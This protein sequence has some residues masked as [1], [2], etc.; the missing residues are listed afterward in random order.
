MSEID[1]AAQ[2]IRVAFEGSEIA[3][4]IA[5]ESVTDSVKL[6]R[7]IVSMFSWMHEKKVYGKEVGGTNIKN[8]ITR[9]SN[10]LACEIPKVSIKDFDIMA[11]KMGILY[12]KIPDF[13]SNDMYYRM[14]FKASDYPKVQ[15]VMNEINKKCKYDF[16]EE[17]LDKLIKKNEKKIE[18]LEKQGKKKSGN[19]NKIMCLKEEIF[20]YKKIKENGLA[21]SAVQLTDYINGIPDNKFNN[22]IGANNKSKSLKKTENEQTLTINM[23]KKNVVEENDKAVKL[24]IPD[25]KDGHVWISKKDVMH[26]DNEN[27][28]LSLKKEKSYMTYSGNNKAMGAMVAEELAWYLGRSSTPV[29]YKTVADLEKEYAYENKLSSMYKDSNKAAIKINEDAFLFNGTRKQD[30]YLI[31]IDEKTSVHVE[32]SSIFKENGGYVMFIDKDKKYDVLKASVTSNRTDN[33][34]YAGSDIIV[35]FE[36]LNRQKSIG[37]SE[38]EKTISDALKQNVGNV[39]RID[40]HLSKK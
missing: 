1:A 23:K 25:V 40:G 9:D 7:K 14:M 33:K 12:T 18:S 32:K 39:V 8:L 5:I 10:I 2:Y 13:D 11:K 16:K 35:I 24:E 29:N 31:M 15:Q 22:V 3:F 17:K 34:K 21:A 28:V 36:K 38:K 37:R 6:I 30:T 4:K 20:E 27:I 19:K 26:M